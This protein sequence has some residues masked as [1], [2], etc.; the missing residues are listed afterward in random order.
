MNAPFRPREIFAALE[1]HGVDYVAV[2]GF[3]MIAHGVIRATLDVDL[4]PDPD[5][6]NLERLALALQELDGSPDGE[7]ATEIDAQLLSRDANMRFQTAAGQVD[8]LH[9]RQYAER[10]ASLRSRAVQG[11]A[12]GTTVTVVARQDLIALKAATGRDRDLAD[13]GDLLAADPQDAGA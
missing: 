5:S 2:G 6:E 3:A 9:A 1:R 4:I 12:E 8:I 11:L 10:Y 13:I 7:P